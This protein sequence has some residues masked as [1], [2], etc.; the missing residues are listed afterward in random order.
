MLEKKKR[1]LIFAFIISEMLGFVS[2]NFR[3]R[4]KECVIKSG[5]SCVEVK[6]EEIK[7]KTERMIH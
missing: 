1:K 4:R 5:M 3:K 6:I 7:M 2:V